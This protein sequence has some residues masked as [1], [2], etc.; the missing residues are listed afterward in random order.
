[1]RYST[2]FLCLVTACGGVT[3]PER[4]GWAEGTSEITDS[5][6]PWLASTWIA[7][8]ECLGVPHDA[9]MF[10]LTRFFFADALDHPDHIGLAGAE[11][12]FIRNDLVDPGR[13]LVL[14]HEIIHRR[15]GQAHPEAD[16]L[17]ER[18]AE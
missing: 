15:T 9:N 12:I 13:T 1:M 8:E 17:M 4:F 14:R 10:A 5:E 7:V 3:D 16:P 11:Y 18:C 2:L 6:A